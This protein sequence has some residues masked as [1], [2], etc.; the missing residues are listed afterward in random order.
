MR[1]NQREVENIE[2]GEMCLRQVARET[3]NTII[4]EQQCTYGFVTILDSSIS[5]EVKSKHMVH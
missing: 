3:C 2:W 5:V 1:T 4:N